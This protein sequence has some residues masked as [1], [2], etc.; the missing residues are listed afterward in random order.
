MNKDEVTEVPVPL[1]IRQL[2]ELYNNKIKEYQQ[3]ALN[4]IQTSSLE[5]MTLMG[6]NPSDGWRLDLD[7]LKFVKV[8]KN[9]ST[10]GNS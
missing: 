5:L 2:A 4:E 8:S 7:N 10:D 6:L 3:V 9:E 1:A